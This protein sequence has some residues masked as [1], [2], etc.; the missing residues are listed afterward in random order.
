MSFLFCYL[1]SVAKVELRITMAVAVIISVIDVAIIICDWH[2]VWQV[3]TAAH[4]FQC[5]FSA[6]YMTPTSHHALASL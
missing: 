2:S 3:S 4:N 1:L 6:G 5:I